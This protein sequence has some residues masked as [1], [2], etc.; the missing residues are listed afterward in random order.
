MEELFDNHNHGIGQ[1]TLDA[2]LVEVFFAAVSNPRSVFLVIDALDECPPS[3][4]ERVF[5][6]L[7]QSTSV[8]ALSIMVTS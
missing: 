8:L 2:P 7:G 4:R 3:L 6:I 5:E 1:P